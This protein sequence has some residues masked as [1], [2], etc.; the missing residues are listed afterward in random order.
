MDLRIN[1]VAIWMPTIIDE[2][3]V[4]TSPAGRTYFEDGVAK[5]TER[6][7]FRY[8]KNYELDGTKFC[9]FIMSFSDKKA[10]VERFLDEVAENLE[11]DFVKQNVA[12]EN[13]HYTDFEFK[14]EE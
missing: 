8:A 6:E 13:F 5:K 7:M 2:L 9:L 14:E 10:S 12:D 4:R 3:T 1:R 11:A